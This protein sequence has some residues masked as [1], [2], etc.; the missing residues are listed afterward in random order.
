MRRFVS[1]VEPSL[2]IS[3]LSAYVN[4]IFSVLSH[5]IWASLFSPFPSRSI[6]SIQKSLLES[7]VVIVTLSSPIV[8]FFVFCLAPGPGVGEAALAFTAGPGL[9]CTWESVE[10]EEVD[11]DFAITLMPK[12]T[13]LAIVSVTTK[14]EI[15]FILNL[16]IFCEY[17]RNRAS[18]GQA[19]G[20]ISKQTAA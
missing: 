12:R 17:Q 4:N 9:N 16:Q 2:H 10:L 11:C 19:G 7:R 6:C 3:V 8:P 1:A 15:L 5:S 18:T 14:I 13:K 20:T